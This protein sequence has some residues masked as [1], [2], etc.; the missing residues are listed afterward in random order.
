MLWCAGQAPIQR[1]SLALRACV[2]MLESRFNNY[3]VTYWF[4]LDWWPCAGA[5][6]VTAGGTW[7]CIW[8][9]LSGGRLLRRLTQHQKTVTCVCLSALAGPQAVA[10]T[11]ML[12]GSLDGHVK[13]ESHTHLSCVARLSLLLFQ[14]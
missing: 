3:L 6:A 13:V 4:V 5:L 11:R 14:G 8:D 1:G 2:S 9:M 10:A 12:S 7:L